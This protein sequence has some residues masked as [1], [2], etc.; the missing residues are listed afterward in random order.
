MRK[1][2]WVYNPRKRKR[3]IS[4]R[5][6][7]RISFACDRFVG[8]YLRLQFMRPFDPKN[9]K[10]PQCVDISWKWHGNFI[11]FKTAYR[12][13]RPDV[14]METYE[15]PI[16]RLEYMDE[17]SFHLAYF[18]HTEEWREIT[19]GEKNSLEECFNF[20]RGLPHFK[21]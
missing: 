3:V 16:A 21:V 2:V 1:K 14:I 10:N 9:K 8:Q 12:D 17:N 19:C 7:M 20:I 4:N 5:T 18:R 13:L 6:R 15:Y 11:Y